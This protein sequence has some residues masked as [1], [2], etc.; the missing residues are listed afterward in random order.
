MSKY[1]CSGVTNYSPTPV[2]GAP[3]GD[4]Q[5]GWLE[6]F[7]RK[8]MNT[9]KQIVLAALL[10][11]L[12]MNARGVTAQSRSGYIEVTVTVTSNGKAAKGTKIEFEGARNSEKFMY[13]W[14][15]RKMHTIHSAG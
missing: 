2:L 4:R 10:L 5:S 15:S 3:D 11:L 6:S 8:T 14:H 12:T 9:L 7:W 1:R 13:N